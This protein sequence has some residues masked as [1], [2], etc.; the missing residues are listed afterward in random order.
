MFFFKRKCTLSWCTG[1]HLEGP[2]LN[3]KKKGAHSARLIRRFDDGLQTVLGVYG[4][5]DTVR[6]ITIAPE[7]D[8]AVDVI[9]ALTERGIRVSLGHSMADL[10]IGEAAVEAGAS[11]I[12]HLFNAMAAFH[13]R[14]P[15]LFG[16]LASS[17]IE[18]RLFY[19][20]IS[21]N[22]HA[23]PSAQRIAFRTD[24]DSAIIVTDAIQAMGLGDGCWTLGTQQVE[25]SGMSA[26]LAGSDTL[27]GSVATMDEC[28]RNLHRA[29]NCPLE[30][31]LES[32]SLNPAAFLGLEGRK[33]SLSFG[34]DADI[35]VLDDDLNVVATFIAG[36]CVYSTELFNAHNSSMS[37]NGWPI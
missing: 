13:H 24:P 17:K 7:I 4:T 11:C 19:G 33:G 20:I 14:D 23:H 29:T 16:L 10:P 31:A 3:V 30:K 36:E 25:I 32:A 15:G 37:Q 2:F 8:G 5:L 22:V 26:T 9:R 18:R 27:A 21:D 34:A 1:A 6:V 12:T 28:I 35:A